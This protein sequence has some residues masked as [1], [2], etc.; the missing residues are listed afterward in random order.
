MAMA[1]LGFGR[2]VIDLAA[3][4]PSVEKHSPGLG[5][6]ASSLY[7]ISVVYRL[8]GDLPR[9]G[10]RTGRPRQSGGGRGIFPFLGL[11]FLYHSAVAVPASWDARNITETLAQ[12]LTGDV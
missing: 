7:W 2:V 8:V 4:G 10:G 5:F 1:A 12:G 11:L 9:R 3:H 6:T